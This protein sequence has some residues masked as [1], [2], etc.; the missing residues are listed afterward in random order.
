[1][2]IVEDTGE[3]LP[4]GKIIAPHRPADSVAAA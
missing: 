3:I 1:M 2:D 4:D